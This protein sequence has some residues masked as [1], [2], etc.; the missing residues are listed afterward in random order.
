MR[1]SL[2]ACLIALSVAA[3]HGQ[4]L[5]TND[6]GEQIIVYPDGSWRYF[7]EPAPQ[8]GGTDAS[9]DRPPGA[10]AA[11]P[12]ERYA[13]PELTAEAEARARNA[14]RKRVETQLREVQTLRKR[15][16]K[17]DER[18]AR[19]LKRLTKLKSDASAVDRDKLEIAT[20]KY[21]DLKREGAAASAELAEAERLAGMLRKSLP[22]TSRQR[23]DYYQQV[24]LAAASDRV[25][26]IVEQAERE[27]AEVER[28]GAA[29]SGA[30]QPSRQPAA[31]PSGPLEYARYD[32]DA[33]PRYTPPAP[34][35]VF[36]Y[37]GVDEFTQRR[38][39]DVAPELF[40]AH[41]NADLKPYL[42]DES[43]ITA[44]GGL[45]RSGSNLALEVTYVIRS[46]FAN[47]E[48]GNLPKGSQLNLRLVDGGTVTLRN[49]RLS[50]GSFDPVD[51][52][53]SFNA[54]YPISSKQE[55]ALRR[56]LVDQVRVM[57]GTGFEDYP[58]YEVDF[59][60]RQIGCL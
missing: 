18:A 33:D 19:E 16:D 48:F 51:K 31:L 21:Q 28:A 5:T 6:A 4:R 49:R 23:R 26:A 53:Y 38:R 43:L 11:V 24:G 20:R 37:E 44:L 34:D 1:T 2:A 55:K 15:R 14:V 13:D 35:C 39:T 30:A 45:V 32:Q 47:R 12:T 7:N 59:F 25:P 41:T 22:M 27:A 40:F 52:V 57:W 46:Q 8:A 58:V 17:L 10:D 36:A 29:L 9:P 56:E 3:V 42:G 54:Q 50:Q 60:Q